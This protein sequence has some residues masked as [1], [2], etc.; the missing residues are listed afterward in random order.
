MTQP[1][2]IDNTEQLREFCNQIKS[3]PWLAIDTEFQREK[4]Y[5]SILALI[6]IATP[7][8][9]AIIDPLACD[10]NPLLDVLYDKNILKIFHAA[11]QDQEIFYDL[12]GEPLSPVFD[13][14]IAAPILGHPEQAGYARLVDDILGVQL[15]KAHS[16]TDWLRRPLSDDQITYAADDVIYLA[17]L[18][19]LLEKQLIEKDRLNWLAPAFSDLCKARLYSNPPELAWKRIRAAKRLKGAPLSTLQKMAEWREE[20]AQSKNIPRG[21]LI[22][23]D[24][25]IEIA[26]LK[27]TNIRT[28]SSIRGVSEKFI[29]KFG[30][31]IIAI[32]S[33][34]ID[35]K[36]ASQEKVKKPKKAS[37]NQEALADLLMAQV[38]LAASAAGVNPT[39]ITTRKELLQL[40]QGEHD[41]ELLCDWRHEMVG[42]DLLL[43]LENKNAFNVSA[44]K[45]AITPRSN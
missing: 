34:A 21:W 45:L 30:D 40:I 19:P 4:T 18:Y 6:Q 26:K 11:R 9:V 1:Q 42:K 39:S 10:I 38:R 22:K 27:P 33:D 28:L 41:I 2:Y 37:E 32:V 3:V 14:Q 12:R 23:D 13:T 20:L 15:S 25:L 7:N 36:P 5:R 17:K 44:G 16:R 35:E 29:D 24:I 43:T 31:T 8:I